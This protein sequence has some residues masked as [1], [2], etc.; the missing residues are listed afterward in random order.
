[1]TNDQQ[2]KDATSTLD[3]LKQSRDELLRKMALDGVHF[4]A[5]N[6]ALLEKRVSALEAAQ[7]QNSAQEELAAIQLA[8]LPENFRD[9]DYVRS[10][11]ARVRKFLKIIFL[12][13]ITGII[14]LFTFIALISRT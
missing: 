11:N 3:D 14:C 7:T 6:F 4:T 5:A 13:V 10:H 2:S 8:A 1:M 9:P 12:I